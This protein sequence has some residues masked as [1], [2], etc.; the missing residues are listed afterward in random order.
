MSELRPKPESAIDW[1]S[2]RYDDK[3]VPISARL[4]KLE[5]GLTMACNDSAADLVREVREALGVPAQEGREPDG[6]QYRIYWSDGWGPWHNVEW[7]IERVRKEQSRLIEN[8]TMQLRPLF[9]SPQRPNELWPLM[10]DCRSQL[11]YIEEKY[12]PT[13]SSASLIARLDA[14]IS[15]SPQKRRPKNSDGG[16]E[17]DTQPKPEAGL[18]AGEESACLGGA[19]CSRAVSGSAL[20]TRAG[21]TPSPSET[22]P[23]QGQPALR[24]PSLRPGIA[25]IIQA[26]AL[27]DYRPTRRD[28]EETADKIITALRLQEASEKGGN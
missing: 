18:A 16:V 28:C 15:A 12:K 6:W 8:G 24:G 14:A 21:V 23:Q 20:S 5:A 22:T 13:A 25:D 17:V 3:S 7:P 1:R 9:A 11:E 10:Y 26:F 4:Q 2:A 19:E 27:G